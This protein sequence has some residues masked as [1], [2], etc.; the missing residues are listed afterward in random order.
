MELYPLRGPETERQY[1]VY[2]PEA[3]LLYASDTLAV[4]KDGS[5]YNP[6]LMHEVAE[7]VFRQWLSVDTVFAMQHGPVP[8]KTVMAMIQQSQNSL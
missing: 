5:L 2:F 6:E 1:V 3:R 8:W 4:R 7:L